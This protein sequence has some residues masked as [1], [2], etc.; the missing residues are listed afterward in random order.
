MHGHLFLVMIEAQNKSCN[1]GYTTVS[2]VFVHLYCI[3]PHPCPQGRGG[4]DELEGRNLES[5]LYVFS[6][7]TKNLLN[8][9]EKRNGKLLTMFVTQNILAPAYTDK[10]L[11]TLCIHKYQK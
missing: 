5:E 2:A 10:I 11:K 3:N 1:L 8:S 4:G 9:S 6:Q 7:A